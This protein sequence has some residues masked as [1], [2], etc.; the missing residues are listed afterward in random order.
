MEPFMGPVAVGRRPIITSVARATK[1]VPTIFETNGKLRDARTLH[2]MTFTALPLAM[3]WILNGPWRSRAR[4]IRSAVL[5]MRR[6]V[7]R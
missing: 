3:N 6:I 5:L 7:S 1:L 4:A 2:S